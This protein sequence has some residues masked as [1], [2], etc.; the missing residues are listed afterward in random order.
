MT[1][2]RAKDATFTDS[3]GAEVR[4]TEVCDQLVIVATKAK[5]MAWPNLSAAQAKRLAD[6]LNRFVERQERAKLQQRPRPQKGN[7]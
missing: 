3:G 2:R 1:Q 5:R 7:P 4:C 6:I